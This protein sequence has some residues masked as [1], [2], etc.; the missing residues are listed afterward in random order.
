MV[1]KTQSTKIP[2]AGPPT[3][4]VEKPLPRIPPFGCPSV[5][6][7][8]PRLPRGRSMV[9]ACPIRLRHFVAGPTPNETNETTSRYKTCV[10]SYDECLMWSPFPHTISAHIVIPSGDQSRTPTPTDI[11]RL[12]LHPLPATLESAQLYAPALR[13]S[14][15]IG[16]GDMRLPHP[17]AIGALLR[18]GERRNGATSQIEL[19]P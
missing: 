15:T 13:P 16:R 4:V 10:F 17:R 6:V 2:L 9:Q 5:A 19:N 7:A 18:K 3:T 8:P 12:P 11:F 1:L 14:S